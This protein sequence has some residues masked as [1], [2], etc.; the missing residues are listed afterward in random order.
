MSVAMSRISILKRSISTAVAGLIFVGLLSPAKCDLPA[1]YRRRLPRSAYQRDCGS[2]IGSVDLAPALVG[3][4]RPHQADV[5]QREAVSAW[6]R[7]QQQ[8]EELDR[9]LIISRGC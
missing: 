3:H 2:C 1:R 8:A 9:K 5:P 7:Q 6:E 4:R